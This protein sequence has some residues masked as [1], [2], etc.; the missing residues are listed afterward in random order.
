MHLINDGV[1]HLSA[2]KIGLSPYKTVPDD[3]GMIGARRFGRAPGALPGHCPGIGIKDQLF[4]VKKQTPG[5]VIR[6][7]ESIAV[8]K[9]FDLQR[10]DKNRID[11][12]G[13]VTLGNTDDRIRHIRLAAEKQQ[14]TGSGIPGINREIYPVIHL[15]RTI[16][17]TIA[18]SDTEARD[19]IEW[20]LPVV[21]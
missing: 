3:P 19:L 11:P 10:I 13:A 15:C 6:P 20:L 9:I 7:V 16:E 8:F 12:A 18:R 5:R 1:L 17:Q 2:G 4:A 21:I 14:F